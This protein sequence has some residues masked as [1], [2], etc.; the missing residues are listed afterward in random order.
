[1]KLTRYTTPQGPRW[2]ADD[3]WLAGAFDL[4]SL[5]AMPRADLGAL[6]ERSLT[7]EPAQGALLAPI[8]DTQEVWASGVTYQRSREARHAELKTGDIYDRVYAAQRPELF[9]KA[10]GWR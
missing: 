3:H 4:R 9:F 6:I 1:M 8:E 5:L 7:A 10:A 2:A